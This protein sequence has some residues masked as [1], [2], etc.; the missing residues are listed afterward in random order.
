MSE[1]MTCNE[2]REGK[3]RL[4]RRGDDGKYAA[5]DEETK[6]LRAQ[7]EAH[8]KECDECR[9]REML[10]SIEKVDFGTP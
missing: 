1:K 2:F 10:L 6:P 3:E 4:F 5:S 9:T 8:L 7:L